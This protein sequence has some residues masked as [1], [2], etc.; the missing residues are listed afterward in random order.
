L[1]SALIFTPAVSSIAHF[2]ARKRGTATGFSATGGSIGGIVFP[3][4]LQRLFPELGWQWSIRILAFIFLLLLI[5]A[6]LLIRSRLPPKAG[7]S[8]WPDLK[9]FR[10]VDFVLVI[11]GVFGM[12]WALFIPLTYITSWAMDTHI[13]SQAFGFQLLAIL[14]AASFF[15]RWLPGYG[16]DHIGRFNTI[17][18]S[19]TMCFFFVVGLW[20]PGTLEGSP[21]RGSTVLAILFAVGFGFSSG[22]NISLTPV[23]IGELCATEEYGRYYATCYTVVSIGC[24]TGLPIVGA[25]MQRGGGSYV[26]SVVFTAAC[27]AASLLSFAIVRI[28]RAG[29]DPRVIA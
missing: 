3:L 6:N 9:I 1:G 20:L 22:S 2:F 8:I 18:I 28:R 16:A 27:Y 21:G 23:C 14:N 13:G 29:W 25:I 15:G 26:G 17:I 7:G 19:L 11:A 5:V 24:L 10:Q 4:A 12:E